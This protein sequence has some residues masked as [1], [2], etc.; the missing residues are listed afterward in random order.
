MLT[1]RAGM[2]SILPVQL[3]PLATA[4]D[5][6][7]RTCGLPLVNLDF[8]KV[9]VYAQRLCMSVYLQLATTLSVLAST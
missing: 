4:A 1:L 8:L 3:L 5:M 6:E 7:L 9:S 2:A